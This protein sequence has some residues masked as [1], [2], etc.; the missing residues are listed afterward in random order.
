[1]KVGPTRAVELLKKA[2]ILVL[3]L[4]TPELKKH[5]QYANFY[6]YL[7]LSFHPRCEFR[8]LQPRLS[9]ISGAFLALFWAHFKIQT[10]VV[11]QT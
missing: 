5:K 4:S 3:R 7:Y 2:R 6:A 11:L 8:K 10:V 1:V 9:V